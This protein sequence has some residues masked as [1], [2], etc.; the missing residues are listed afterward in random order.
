MT[1][2]RPPVAEE[3]PGGVPSRSVPDVEGLVTRA[4]AACRAPAPFEPSD[5]PF[6]D[7]PHIAVGLLAAHLD[8]AVEAASRPG[9]TIDRA[10]AWLADRGLVGPGT[11]VLDL[12]CGPG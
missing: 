7:D 2:G 10:V 11:R 3:L 6:W 1:T 4:V 8:D 9:A 5:A 12:G